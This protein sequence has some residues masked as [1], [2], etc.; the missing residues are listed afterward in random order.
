MFAVFVTSMLIFPVGLYFIDEFLSTRVLFHSFYDF[1]EFDVR[2]DV[3]SIYVAKWWKETDQW[4][5]GVSYSKGRKSL[6]QKE[7]VKHNGL[8]F[9]NW[10]NFTQNPA[11]LNKAQYK[12]KLNARTNDTLGSGHKMNFSNGDWHDKCVQICFDCQLYLFFPK[13]WI[14]AQIVRTR[15]RSFNLNNLLFFCFTFY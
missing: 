11:D 1:R 12:S 9:V 14:L 5:K 4:E 6:I 8:W 15:T 7:W 3:F 10:K 13:N 2:I